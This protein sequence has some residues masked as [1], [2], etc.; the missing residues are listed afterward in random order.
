MRSVIPVL[1]LAFCIPGAAFAQSIQG[2]LSAADVNDELLGVY[3]EG[4]SGLTNRFWSECIEPDGSSIYVIEGE[5]LHGQMSIS[6]EG[7][8]CFDYEQSY[9]PFGNC[10]SVFRTNEEGYVFSS[11]MRGGGTFETTH[12]VRNVETCPFSGAEIG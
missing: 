3:L 8:V 10:F 4:V 7:Y 5:E 12:I 9:S 6:E 1:I 2:V 11:A